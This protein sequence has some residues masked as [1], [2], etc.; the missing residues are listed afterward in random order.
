MVRP[1]TMA[2]PPKRA[3]VDFAEASGGIRNGFCGRT[4]RGDC[5]VFSST[6]ATFGK[7]VADLG[8]LGLLG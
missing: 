5:M 3:P 6:A 2:A 7:L 8:R 4:N 1:A